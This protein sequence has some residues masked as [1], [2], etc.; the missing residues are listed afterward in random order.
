[1]VFES[2]VLE[3]DALRI[4]VPNPAALK[5]L[6]DEIRQGRTMPLEKLLAARPQDFLLPA[7]GADPAAERYYCYAWGLA[8]YL[9]FARN[10]LGTPALD[11]YVAADAAN[12]PPAARLERLGGGPG[13]AMPAPDG[14]AAVRRAADPSSGFTGPAH[15]G[16]PAP[17]PVAIAPPEMGAL[18]EAGAAP[19]SA[20]PHAPREGRRPAGRKCP[21]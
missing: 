11:R 10:V 3:P 6:R 19:P 20:A 2:G 12:T 8:Y 9:T 16:G 18:P 5:R 15:A 13:Q 7:D 4:D 17:L 21:A 14:R 1:M